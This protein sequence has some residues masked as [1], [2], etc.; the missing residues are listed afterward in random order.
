MVTS[1]PNCWAEGYC[2]MRISIATRAQHEKAWHARLDLVRARIKVV[3]DSGRADRSQ[4]YSN[5]DGPGIAA[6]IR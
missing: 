1:S 2:L 4:R 6:A 3:A 5:Q